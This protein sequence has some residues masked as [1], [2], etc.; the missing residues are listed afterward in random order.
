MGDDIHF[1]VL[2]VLRLAAMPD[3]DEKHALRI[4]IINIIG[5]KLK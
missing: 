1:L 4:T 3:G 5:P 2:E